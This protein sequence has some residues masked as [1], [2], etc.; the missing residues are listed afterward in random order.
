MSTRNNARKGRTKATPHLLQ[1]DLRENL[2]HEAGDGAVTD[3]VVLDEK[4]GPVMHRDLGMIEVNDID[5]ITINRTKSGISPVVP[6]LKPPTFSQNSG[7]PSGYAVEI[8]DDTS[9]TGF[10]HV[11][12]VSSNYLLLSN[13]EV[14]ELAVEVA[15]QSGLPFKESRVFWDGARFCHVID[16][17]ESEEV[18]PGDGIGLS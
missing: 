15:V 5:G 16:F 1:E 4:E 17:L 2:Q 11:G 7:T 9:E 18:E 3:A 14:R 6:I 13:Q 8:E 10:R 12:N